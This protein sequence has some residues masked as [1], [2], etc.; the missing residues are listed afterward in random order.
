MFRENNPYAYTLDAL[1]KENHYRDPSIVSTLSLLK[2]VPYKSDGK[3]VAYS[4]EE[5]ESPEIK[6]ANNLEDFKSLFDN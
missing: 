4:F 6:R 5:D 3:K 2:S 1:P